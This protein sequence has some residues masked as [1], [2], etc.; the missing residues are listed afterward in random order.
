MQGI[1]SIAIF[2]AVRDK[3]DVVNLSS[4][5]FLQLAC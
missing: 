3:G 5:V 2:L 1:G 4:I